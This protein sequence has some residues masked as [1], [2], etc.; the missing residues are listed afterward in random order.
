MAIQ[1]PAGYGPAAEEAVPALTQA[2]QDDWPDVRHHA[3][4]A[5]KK[6]NAEAAKP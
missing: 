4:V 6:I 2:L 5:L 3:A 1:S